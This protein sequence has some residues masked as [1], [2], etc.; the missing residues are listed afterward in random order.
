MELD[1]EVK[2]NGNSYTT[3]FRQYDPRLGR[4]LSLDPLMMKFPWMSPYVAF[5]NNPVLYVDPYGLESGNGQSHSMEGEPV[6]TESGSECDDGR[7]TDGGVKGG[8]TSVTPSE[9]GVKTE[10]NGK[11]ITGGKNEHFESPETKQ[12]TNSPESVQ[13]ASQSGF[14]VHQFTNSIAVY[15]TSGPEGTA[16]KARYGNDEAKKSLV[17]KQLNKA[18]VYSDNKKFQTGK[19]AYR[20]AMSSGNNVN[21][22]KK[23]ADEFVRKQFKAARKSLNKG[24]IENAYFELGVALHTLQDATSPA[25]GGFQIWTGEENLLEEID[26]VSQEVAYPG[27][28]SNLQGITIWFLDIFESGS[29]LPSGNIFD[30]IKTD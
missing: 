28:T 19:T 3:E 23:Q 12:S 29:E 21:K 9:G 1:N 30:N 10:I 18:T 6:K 13:W 17:L 20:H 11:S 24:D 4:W 2:G 22:S 16:I 25:H 15:G 27:T 8:S 5:D 14:Y 7:G 26:H